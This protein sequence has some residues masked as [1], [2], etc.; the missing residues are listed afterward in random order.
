MANV[1]KKTAADYTISGN[2]LICYGHDRHG[3]P[4]AILLKLDVYH[5]WLRYTYRF[6]TL[7]SC[8][9]QETECEMTPDEYWQVLAK[10]EHLKDLTDFINIPKTPLYE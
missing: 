9:G 2:N 6:R 1:T 4:Q 5:R 10:S 3:L 7:I 8:D